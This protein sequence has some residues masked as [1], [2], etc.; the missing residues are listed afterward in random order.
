M[1]TTEG[2]PEPTPP[3]APKS[4][5]GKRLALTA[6]PL[7]LAG[8]VLFALAAGDLGENLVYYWTPK[9]LRAAG[10]KAYGATVRLGGMVQAGSVVNGA[11][12]ML[13]FTVADANAQVKVRSKGVPPQMFREGIGVVVEGAYGR[14]EV[15]QATRLM[16]SHGNEYKP[17]DGHPVDAKEL[18][19]TTAGL[20]GEEKR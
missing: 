14:D 15:F 10:D 6:I 2:T 4:K 16:V 12:S 17:P 18:M 9:D 1:S 20:E 13:E 11:G 8:A 5:L 3:E 19:K 7:V